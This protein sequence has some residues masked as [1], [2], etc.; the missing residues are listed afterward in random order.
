MKIFIQNEVFMIFPAAEG[1]VSSQLKKT[2]LIILKSGLYFIKMSLMLYLINLPTPP[3]I[4]YGNT[5]PYSH[6]N[7]KL[8]R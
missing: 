3:R 7:Y 6:L 4:L 8:K 1:Q 5:I 2:S